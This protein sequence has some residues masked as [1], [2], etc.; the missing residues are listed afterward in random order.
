MATLRMK[1]EPRAANLL[2]SGIIFSAVG[3]LTGLV[4]YGFQ[5]IIGRQ[6]EHGEYGLVN[7]TL[8][9]CGLFS[10]PN[11]FAIAAVTHFIALYK[12]RG[13]D[14]RLQGLLAGCHKFLFHLTA[15][16]SVFAII[17]V[18]PLSH[19]FHFPRAGLMLV[20]LAYV[21]VGLWSSYAIAFCQGLAWFIRL[22]FIGLFAAILRILFGWLATKIWPMAE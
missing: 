12:G 21:L 9:F 14:A 5:G 7:T 16:G 1:P 10:L 6:L 8:S 4:N 2:Q 22:A 13:D 3:L 19:F 18:I 15:A 11:V 20:A 17:F